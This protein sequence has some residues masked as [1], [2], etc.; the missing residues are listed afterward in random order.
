MSRRR[1]KL[2]RVMTPG[3]RAAARSL[4]TPRP[5]EKTNLAESFRREG[6]RAVES[7]VEAAI[8]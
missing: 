8:D 3:E 1:E 5:E 7:K 4:R 6:E 2:L